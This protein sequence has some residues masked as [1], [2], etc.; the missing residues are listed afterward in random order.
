MEATFREFLDSILWPDRLEPQLVMRRSVRDP[1][2]TSS[3]TF[4]AQP[5]ERDTMSISI[6]E[7]LRKE[8]SDEMNRGVVKVEAQRLRELALRS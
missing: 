6:E 5:G 4:T 2:A 3:R 7:Q 8:N 1:A